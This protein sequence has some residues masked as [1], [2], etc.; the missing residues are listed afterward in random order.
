VKSRTRGRGSPPTQLPALLYQY[1]PIRLS[2]QI[3]GRKWMLL[4]I[5]DLAFLKLS[6]FGEFRRNNPGLTPRVLSRCLRQ[7]ESEKLLVRKV[8]DRA[9]R[10]RLTKRGED[11]ALVVLAFLQYGLKHHVGPLPPGPQVLDLTPNERE[12]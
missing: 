2:V 5:R 12:R 3:L 7:L 9:I 10:Y 8:A 4:L 11:A 6:R 1:D